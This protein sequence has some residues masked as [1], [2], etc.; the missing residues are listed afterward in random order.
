TV[1][2]KPK[3]YDGSFESFDTFLTHLKMYFQAKSNEYENDMFD[4]A[5]IRDALMTMQEG[6]AAKWGELVFGE[7]EKA[8]A[9]GRLIFQNWAAFEHRLRGSFADPNKKE[10]AQRELHAIR[11]K[12]N[13]SMLDF[14]LRFDQL[15]FQAG[16]S[17]EDLLATL[18]DAVEP[19]LFLCAVVQTNVERTLESWKR[20]L[21]EMDNK[22]RAW[23][24]GKGKER[25]STVEAPRSDG[26]FEGRGRGG[27]W[28]GRGRGR[29]TWVPRG[30][31]NAGQRGNVP[32]QA[33]NQPVAS[34]STSSAS[35]PVP[36]P[37]TAGGRV[38]GGPGEPMDVDRARTRRGLRCWVCNT[39][40]HFA[41]ECPQRGIRTMW[42][43]MNNEER[44][45]LIRTVKV[46]EEEGVEQ[47]EEEEYVEE[48]KQDEAVSQGPQ[49]EADF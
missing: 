40:G 10:N 41:S 17:E 37:Q 7:M 2:A 14:L 3:P 25:K 22:R 1:I 38:F 45:E 5:K 47:H 46:L 34:T 18:R 13:E 32:Q 12:P 33:N 21:L 24:A 27:P 35:V 30:N 11:Q 6:R 48:D 29:G 39:L 36:S 15:Q 23:E 28:F 44:Q 26:R 4:Q 19:D 8:A 20:H 49:S 9:Q 16:F 43:E 31:W 42:N